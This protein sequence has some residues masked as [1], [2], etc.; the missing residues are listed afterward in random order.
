MTTEAINLIHQLSTPQAALS[1]LNEQ[2]DYDIS[3]DTLEHILDSHLGGKTEILKRFRER[4]WLW[5]HTE[6][7]RRLRHWTEELPVDI[8]EHRL[9]RISQ[10]EKAQ[11]IVL[12]RK[13]V[14]IIA[15]RIPNY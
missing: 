5:L 14:S 9:I 12:L 7:S 8:A 13:F 6:L 1:H 3:D 15:K 11:K 4:D 10:E 2:D